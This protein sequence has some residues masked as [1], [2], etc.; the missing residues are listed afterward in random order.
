M[1]RKTQLGLMQ[2][3]LNDMWLELSE[4]IDR[5]LGERLT[6]SELAQKCFYNPS[7]FSR[8]FKEKFGITLGDYV[9]RQRARTALSLLT[10]SDLTVDAIACKCGYTDKSGLYRAIKKHFGESPSVYRKGEKS[11]NPQ[12]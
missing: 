2:G 12:P 3:E 10:E 1:L 8:I 6:L 9:A 4:Y 7:Y 11:K 5:N